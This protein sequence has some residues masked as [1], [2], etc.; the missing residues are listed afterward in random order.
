MI[1]P[2]DGHGGHVGLLANQL[3]IHCVAINVDTFDGKWLV[4]VLLKIAIMALV[5]I[6]KRIM[7]TAMVCEECA[8]DVGHN[9]PRG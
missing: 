6:G 3:E 8:A 5:A 2:D 7:I 9:Y 4:M 1:M